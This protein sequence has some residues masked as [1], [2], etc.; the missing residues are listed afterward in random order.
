MVEVAD[1]G[2]GHQKACYKS[3]EKQYDRYYFPPIIT[4][5]VGY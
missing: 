1:E 2:D 5:G 4:H 3:I